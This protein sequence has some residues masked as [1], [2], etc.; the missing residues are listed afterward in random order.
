MGLGKNFLFLTQTY[1]RFAGD[2]SGPFIRELARGLVRAGDQ[3]TVL[4]P[5]LLR[6]ASI[7][8]TTG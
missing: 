8:T 4:T 2:T 1:P 7:G 6:S 3:V 5:M